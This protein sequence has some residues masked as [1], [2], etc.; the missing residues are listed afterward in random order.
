MLKMGRKCAV[1]DNYLDQ[2]WQSE[3]I[4]K[5]KRNL[6]PFLKLVTEKAGLPADTFIW[7]I[8][9]V[10]DTLYCEVLCVCLYTRLHRRVELDF[11]NIFRGLSAE[12]LMRS[13]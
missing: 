9:D 7:N 12:Y 5:I 8:E 6:E 4:Q 11:V 2:Y 10:R 3:H 13:L 1:L